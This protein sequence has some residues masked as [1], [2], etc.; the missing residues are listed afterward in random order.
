MWII[1]LG[2]RAVNRREGS[3][4]TTAHLFRDAKGRRNTPSALRPAKRASERHAEV[5]SRRSVFCSGPL[6]LG[7]SVLRELTTP[8]CARRRFGPKQATLTSR[9]SRTRQARAGHPAWWP[10][11]TLAV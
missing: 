5:N 11:E 4:L 8:A 10:G 6:D 7:V 9:Q 3:N 2:A 1:A